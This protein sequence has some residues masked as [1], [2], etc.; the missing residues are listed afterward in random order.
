[1]STSWCADYT[2]HTDKTIF[3]GKPSYPIGKRWI[4]YNLATFLTYTSSIP[5]NENDYLCKVQAIQTWSKIFVL[6][7]FTSFDRA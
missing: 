7:V 1:M 5:F 4:D 3:G 2:A 6:P